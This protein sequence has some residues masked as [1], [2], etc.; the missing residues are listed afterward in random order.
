MLWINRAVRRL[1]A[2]IGVYGT[3]LVLLAPLP[4][5]AQTGPGGVGANNGSSTL[6]FWLRSDTGITYGAGANIQSWA[7][8]SGNGHDVTQS[9]NGRMPDHMANSLNGKPSV[10]FRRPTQD[11][12]E[13]AIFPA[14]NVQDHTLFVV[15][16]FDDTRRNRSI[17]CTD[18][19]AGNHSIQFGTDPT[20]QYITY[21]GNYSNSV[22]LDGMSTFGSYNITTLQRLSTDSINGWRNATHLAVD[23]PVANNTASRIRLFRLGANRN[24]V[25][26]I[27]MRAVEYAFYSEALNLAE[28][29]IVQNHLSARYDIGLDQD[30]YYAGD[31]GANGDRDEDV[32]GIGTESDGSHTASH[33]GGGLQLTQASNFGNGDYLFAG[34]DGSNNVEDTLDLLGVPGL[35]ARWSRTWYFDLTDAGAAMTIDI[36]FDFSESGIPEQPG[37]VSNYRLL[38]RP[39]LAGAW[40]DA[41][42]A[43]GVVNDQVSFTGVALSN[44]DGQYTLGTLDRVGSPLPIELEA[45]EATA[46]EW[47]VA[48]DWRTATETENAGFHVERSPDGQ[49]WGSIGWVDGAGTTTSPQFYS[50]SDDAPLDGWSY[51]RL[52]QVDWDGDESISPIRSVFRNGPVSEWTVFPNPARNGI[53]LST[54]SDPGPSAARIRNASGAIV[55]ELNIDSRSTAVDVS[56]LPAGT[57]H[58]E[59]DAPRGRRTLPLVVVGR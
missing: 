21:K 58:I 19:I 35:E 14:Q 5:A 7:D 24:D 54:G 11:A 59:I 56:D 9:A 30:D 41:G 51:Y 33:N 37:D 31:T 10:R 45:F 23:S 12:M 3:F 25:T 52:R 20:A 36:L 40:T 18:T 28:R 38:Y 34:H 26:Y 49:N 29:N 47:N 22:V 13:S 4:S 42:S 32:I 48:L 44:G 43:T 27:N 17:F 6:E 55:R 16:R 15:F 46:G 1:A 53:T 39:G 8:Q 2:R 50:T 57:Y